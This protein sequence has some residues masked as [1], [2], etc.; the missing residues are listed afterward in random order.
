M[1]LTD[2]LQRIRNIGHAEV[3]FQVKKRQIT[4]ANRVNSGP[5]PHKEVSYHT[6]TSF[7]ASPKKYG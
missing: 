1:K 5:Q 7:K 3:E 4:L 6:I 2:K